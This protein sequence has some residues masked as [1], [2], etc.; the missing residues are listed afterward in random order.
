MVELDSTDTWSSSVVKII[1]ALFVFYLL[2]GGSWLILTE[3]DG[4]L[5]LKIRDPQTLSKLLQELMKKEKPLRFFQSSNDRR[6]PK[7]SISNMQNLAQNV[8]T[9]H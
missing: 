1:E 5:Y 9:M 6:D 8:E 7:N 3:I 2:K 4:H